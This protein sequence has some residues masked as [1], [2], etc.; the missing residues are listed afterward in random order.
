ML[1]RPS[2]NRK[3]FCMLNMVSTKLEV[4]FLI[5]KHNNLSMH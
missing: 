3:C 4:I 2:E 1:V 5:C